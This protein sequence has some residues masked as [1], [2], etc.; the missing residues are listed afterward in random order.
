M[1]ANQ[2]E[3]AMKLMLGKKMASSQVISVAST[4]SQDF[5]S[6]FLVQN[7]ALTLALREK[8]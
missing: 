5:V 6:A 3:K 7:H 1:S 4:L 8:Q 2:P